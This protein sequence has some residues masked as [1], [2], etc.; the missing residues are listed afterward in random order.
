MWHSF[1]FEVAQTLR[2]ESK[3]GDGARNVAGRGDSTGSVQPVLHYR[4]NVQQKEAQAAAEL[5][6]VRRKCSG[7]EQQTSTRRSGGN[8]RA[9]ATGRSL[10]AVGSDGRI[11]SGIGTGKV[12]THDENEGLDAQERLRGPD[13]GAETTAGVQDEQEK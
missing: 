3:T 13:L 6:G 4:E 9:V 8:E 1:V 10:S 5:Q 2:S 7:E 12:Q 11:S